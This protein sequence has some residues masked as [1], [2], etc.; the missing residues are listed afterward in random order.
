[1]TQG[2]GI[3]IVC[4]LIECYLYGTRALGYVPLASIISAICMHLSNNRKLQEVK[5]KSTMKI[6]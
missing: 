3:H 4:D 6:N 5:I 1:M 2:N